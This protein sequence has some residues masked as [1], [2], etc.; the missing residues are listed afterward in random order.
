MR[1]G[2]YKLRFGHDEEA[3]GPIVEALEIFR[4]IL[5]M[6]LEDETLSRELD[7]AM[8]LIARADIEIYNSNP[9]A[10]L[11]FLEEALTITRNVLSPSHRL[12][13]GIQTQIGREYFSLGQFEKALEL[14]SNAH[15]LLTDN[16]A[17]S[18][19]DFRVEYIVYKWLL[20]RIRNA[21]GDPG[22]A[23][24][25]LDEA[26][27]LF[28][29]TPQAQRFYPRV[30]SEYCR[31]YE[32]LGQREAALENCSKAIDLHTEFFGEENIERADLL[33]QLADLDIGDEAPA[34]YAE[35]DRIRSSQLDPSDWRFAEARA[36]V[37]MSTGSEISPEL[38]EQL[39]R[40]QLYAA[41][42][43]AESLRAL[44]AGQ[45]L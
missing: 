10:G 15:Q 27:A 5:D 44:A 26:E 33:I 23:I 2:Q 7:L 20:A 41:R 6:P 24:E 25:I 9:T 19:P 1:L 31:G 14:Q 22:A 38:L 17:P 36:L 28:S 35:A 42:K 4:S 11:P 18:T 13:L 40:H 16:F 8:G 34:L 21:L 29:T 32:L 43:R 45:S 3:T 12:N 30:Y 37:L 39:S